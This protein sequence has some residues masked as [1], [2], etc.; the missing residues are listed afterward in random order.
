MEAT[1]NPAISEATGATGTTAA[2]TEPTGWTSVRSAPSYN[3]TVTLAS[4]PVLKIRKATA[5]TD[6]AEA[7]LLGLYV[8]YLPE[9]AHSDAATGTVTLS[10]SVEESNEVSGPS[11]DDSPSGQ[12]TL[13]GSVVESALTVYYDNVSGTLTLSGSATESY[14][15]TDSRSGTIRLSGS[16]SESWQ[17]SEPQTWNDSAS[18]TIVLSGTLA[19]STI[20][21]ASPTGTIVLSG[22]RVEGLAFTDD[23]RYPDGSYGSG[24]Y[25][26]GTYG[27]NW[28]ILL[29]R[30]SLVE[31]L[32]APVIDT[33]TGTI[34]LQGS[35]IESSSHSEA[36]GGQLTLSGTRTESWSH[37]GINNDSPVG[38]ILL[39]GSV[40]EQYSLSD[41][42]TG[43]ILL[44]RERGRIPF[45]RGCGYRDPIAL[46]FHH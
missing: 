45:V 1:S 4:Q 31:A 7:D 35:V 42:V 16:V 34:T 13:S 21:V 19:L 15:F 20:R 8:E 12:I 18:G 29:L 11:Y 23:L 37:A 36:I 40:S 33:P 9:T 14:L 27:V 39:S 17:T 25:G 28:G 43:T 38:S 41:S 30:G 3:P 46:R 22:T 10:G 26:S 5:S 44:S 6:V 2:G 32:N 24:I